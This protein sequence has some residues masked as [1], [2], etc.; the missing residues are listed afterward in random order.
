MRVRTRS[1]RRP[2]RLVAPPPVLPPDP[3][4]VLDGPLDPT[5]VAIRT[6]LLPHRRRLWMRRLVRRGWLAVAAAVL[7]ELILWSVAR[8]V[9]LE[10][11]RLVGAAI[12]LVALA[13]WLVA[14]VRARPGLG[15]TALA[16]DAEAAA[17]RPRLE[18]ARAGRGI[19]GV[20]RAPR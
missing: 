13:G 17:R 10:S 20:G 12:P 11:A 5:L 14:G 6:T 18:R 3:R 1:L 19:P 7:A 2:R 9:P 4:A 15:A 16:V 8:V